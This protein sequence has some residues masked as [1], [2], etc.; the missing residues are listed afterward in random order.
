MPVACL[1]QVDLI[2]FE[3]Q[4]RGGMA[5]K[6]PRISVVINVKVE[7]LQITM[8][9]ER[10]QVIVSLLFYLDCNDNKSYVLLFLL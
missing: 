6:E 10:R 4:F 2:F 9:E 5:V 7:I 1:K 3:E 8:K